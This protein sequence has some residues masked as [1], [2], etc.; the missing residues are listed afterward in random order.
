MRCGDL[1]RSDV[2]LSEKIAIISELNQQMFSASGL[3]ELVE[4]LLQYAILVPEIGET[5]VDLVGTGGDGFKTLNF[6]TLA[7]FV[8]AAAGTPMAK[9]GNK[10]VTSKCG[11]FDLLQRMQV[12]LPKDAV[13]ARIEFAKNQLVFLF[14]PYF[15][16]VMAEVVAARKHFADLGQKTIFNCIGPLLNPARVK[17]IV[18]GVFAPELIPAYA[19]ALQYFGV[20]SAYIVHGSGLDEITLTGPTQY[21]KIENGKISFGVWRVADFALAECNITELEGG[22]P[23]QNYAA[24]KALFA[25]ELTGPKSDMVLLNAAAAIRVWSDFKLDWQQSLQ[26]AR[27]GLSR[28]ELAG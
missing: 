22:G 2:S 14:A 25:E 4:E 27:R 1:V 28:V 6:S 5:A 15:H 10:A 21:A 20:Q 26:K 13:A 19:E 11:S 7:T 18:A 9:H 23:A 16:P 3:I 24:A 17:R 8:A 12:N